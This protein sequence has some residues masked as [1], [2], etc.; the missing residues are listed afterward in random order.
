M[1]M[2]LNE[3]RK[4]ACVVLIVCVLLSVFALGGGALGRER[5]KVMKVFN[6]G[7]DTSLA[8]RHSMDAYL[9]AAGESAGIMANEAEIHTGESELG[10]AALANAALIGEDS[11]DLDAR[12]KAYVDLKGQ[13]EKL[14]NNMYSAVSTDEFR[15]FK[16]AYDDFWGYDDML[17]RDEYHKLAK[18]YNSLI[19]GF[20][21]GVVA[22]LTGQGT[23]NTFGG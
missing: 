7:A 19:S 2:R 5:R 21:G 17:G 14:Y 12:Y 3:N 15:N 13:V 22:T 9:D 16:L 1:D 18:S 20:P 23:L 6:D 4:L 8:T 10:N 11:A